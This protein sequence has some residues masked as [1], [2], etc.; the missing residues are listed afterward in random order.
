[1]VANETKP[2]KSHRTKFTLRNLL[3]LVFFVVQVFV[4]CYFWSDIHHPTST[5]ATTTTSVKEEYLK[6]FKKMNSSKGKQIKVLPE[7][8][9]KEKEEEATQ[10]PSNNNNTLDHNINCTSWRACFQENH[11]QCLQ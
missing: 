9:E 2:K 1:M 4:Q 7:E 11:Q 8:E 10:T 6:D 5:T 3:L